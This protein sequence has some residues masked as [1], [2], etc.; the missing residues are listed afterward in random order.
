MSL[1]IKKDS[2]NMS[3]SNKTRFKNNLRET[4]APTLLSFSKKSHIVPEK[5]KRK[6]LIFW[7]INETL[8]QFHTFRKRNIL[9]SSV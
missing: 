4:Q 3:K 8:H 9:E 2:E 1:E 7:S 5:G 6:K